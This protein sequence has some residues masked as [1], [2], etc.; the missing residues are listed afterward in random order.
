MMNSLH[1]IG[2]VD[3]QDVVVLSTSTSLR[4]GNL[5]KV[6]VVLIMLGNFHAIVE[7]GV[8][9]EHKAKRGSSWFVPPSFCISDLWVYR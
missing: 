5:D 4:K 7:L 9:G 3:V 6:W 1:T 2:E 8:V